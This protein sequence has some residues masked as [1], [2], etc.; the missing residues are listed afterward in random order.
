MELTRITE[1]NIEYFIPLLPEMKQQKDQIAIGLIGADESPVASMILRVS[2]G[3]VSIDWIYVLPDERRKGN[4]SIFLEMVETLLAEDSDAFSISYSDGF[5]GLEE[6][7][8]ANGF[9]LTEGNPVW[10]LPVVNAIRL[11]EIRKMQRVKLQGDAIPVAELLSGRRKAL[12]NFVK[13]EASAAELLETCV[14]EMSYVSLNPEGE[15][16]GCLFTERHLHDFYLVSLL[17]NTGMQTNAIILVNK[18]LVHCIEN[19]MDSVV[20]EFVSANESVDRFIHN[21]I[22]TG[23]GITNTRMKY[24]VLSI[25]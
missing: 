17:L 11:P 8:A 2:G 10:I 7:L 4:G 12:V 13:R 20:L 1:E 19:N 18:L 22:G 14:P 23:V 6:F 25:K 24:A 15:I 5:E 21:M 9:V 16:V 3:M